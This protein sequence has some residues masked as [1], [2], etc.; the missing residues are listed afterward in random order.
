MDGVVR[1]PS[2]L[3]ITTGSPPSITAMHELVVPKS[4]PST[5]D[6][7]GFLS[8]GQDL[9]NGKQVLYHHLIGEHNIQHN[10]FTVNNLPNH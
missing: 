6:I 2:A 5:F 1:M 8:Y 3:G 4:I 9:L 10:T 7:V